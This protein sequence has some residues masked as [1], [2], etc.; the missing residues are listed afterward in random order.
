MARSWCC[1]HVDV[2]NSF[3]T[4]QFFVSRPDQQGQTV[5]NVLALQGDWSQIVC[6]YVH[7][8]ES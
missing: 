2:E 8:H 6:L 5:S 7:R 1:R 4:R 3:I